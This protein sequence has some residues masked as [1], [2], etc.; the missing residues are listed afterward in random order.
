MGLVL[1]LAVA[2]APVCAE[3]ATIAGTV[4][5]AEREGAPGDP[6][7]AV[8]WLEVSG[9]SVPAGAPTHAK[10]TMRDK[11]FEPAVVAVPVGSSVSFP[12]GDPILHNVFSVS[13]GNGF[14][15]GLYGQGSGREVIFTQPGVVRVFCNVHPQMEAFIVVTPGP[16]FAIAAKDG[17]FRIDGAPEGRYDVHVWSERGGTAK[18]TVEASAGATVSVPFTLDATRYRPKPHLDKDGRPY[19]G[20]EK[21]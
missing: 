2:A 13:S 20:R 21:Y 6:S 14:D 7:G 1:P 15:L 3:A 4:T 19:T 11:R 12:N 9:T 16:W 5:I 8:V 18:E 17:S 10:V